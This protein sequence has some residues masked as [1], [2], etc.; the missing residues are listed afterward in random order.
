LLKP[1]ITAFHQG[2]LG[3][4][5]Q[6][7]S[8]VVLEISIMN[9]Y[10]KW[11]RTLIGCGLFVVVASTVGCATEDGTT[12]ATD[13]RSLNTEGAAAAA[14][15][16]TMADEEQS[17]TGDEEAVA[18]TKQAVTFPFSNSLHR[19]YALIAEEGQMMDVGTN[20]AVAFGASGVYNGAYTFAILSGY[21][22]C[23]LENFPG[24]PYPGKVKRC[25]KFNALWAA[26]EY[27]GLPS[28]GSGIGNNRYWSGTF[29]YGT[30]LNNV[31]VEKYGAR[32]CT[33]DA[34]GSDPQPGARKHCWGTT[35]LI[36]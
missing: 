12:E 22:R 21:V 34:F 15:D 36:K 29:Y 8:I 13:D 18:S 32:T 31:F 17:E 1:V 19:N 7:T 23:G 30:G 27:W 33:N 4:I 26:D 2:K 35:G 5:C 6:L 24:D 14:K 16:Q 11:F 25:F 28:A 9:M 20:A 10:G 3:G